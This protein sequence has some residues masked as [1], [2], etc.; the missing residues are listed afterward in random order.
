MK[1][2]I[3][4]LLFTVGA[5]GNAP[6]VNDDPFKGIP[7]VGAVNYQY[8]IT[9]TEVTVAQW[10][11]FAN[12]YAPFYTN[13]RLHPEITGDWVSPDSLDPDVPLTFSAPEHARR[14][15]M[16]TTWR[17]AARFCNW[18]HHGKTAEAW[19]FESGVYDTST[20]GQDPNTNFFTDQSAPSPGAKYW[21]PSYDEWV[22]AAY[23]DPDK[24][25]TGQGGY[26][27]YP[28][29]SD[30]APISALPQDGGETNAGSY[31]WDQP[32]GYLDVGSYPH[33]TS[34]WG[35]LDTSGGLEEMTGTWGVETEPSARII[36]GSSLY[37]PDIARSD[38]IDSPGSSGPWVPFLGFRIATVIPSPVGS[39]LFA[40]TIVGMAVARTR[41]RS[42]SFEHATSK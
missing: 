4:M 25:G 19:A 21:L 5:P 41:G 42:R 6:Y 37:F 18:L 16:G 1:Q 36:L 34:P 26:W 17:M 12:A 14:F 32:W 20:F 35:L 40:F 31:Y 27:T 29:T 15:A 22:K 10:L 39:S 28:T 2:V 3:R 33:V 11:E 9:R 38:R 23:Y 30:T 8:R 24:N 13:S 7:P